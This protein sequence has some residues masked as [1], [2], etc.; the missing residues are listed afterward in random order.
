MCRDQRAGGPGNS[1]LVQQAWAP[2]LLK[3]LQWT[4]HRKWG[5]GEMGKCLR[6]LCSVAMEGS[7]KSK[8]LYQATASFLSCIFPKTPWLERE[9]EKRSQWRVSLCPDPKLPTALPLLNPLLSYNFIFTEAITFSSIFPFSRRSFKI[10]GQDSDGV[11]L[12][13]SQY[14]IIITYWAL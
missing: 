11:I 2:H 4:S 10:Q 1:Q 7:D 12:L 13:Y 14:A 6:Q 8:C 3:A 9:R 5:L